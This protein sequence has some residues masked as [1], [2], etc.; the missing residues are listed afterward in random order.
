MSITTLTH[1]IS[2]LKNLY[3]FQQTKMISNK[4]DKEQHLETHDVLLEQIKSLQLKVN[5][6]TH[7]HIEKVNYMSSEINE[8]KQEYEALKYESE[9]DYEMIKDLYDFNKKK[10]NE[11]EILKK[12]N[13]DLENEIVELKKQQQHTYTELIGYIKNLKLDINKLK[14]QN[15][16]KL[17]ISKIDKEKFIELSKLNKQHII[18]NLYNLECFRLSLGDFKE[19]DISQIDKLYSNYLSK[20]EYIINYNSYGQFIPAENTKQLFNGIKLSHFGTPYEMKD[21]IGHRASSNGGRLPADDEIRDFV[22]MF[23][24]TY[25]DKFIFLVK[26]NNMYK[27]YVYE[28]I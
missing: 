22:K 18:M 19:K 20:K 6:V 28:F 7:D 14:E 2:D 16:N 4:Q 5:E 8:L 10:V 21:G 13:E 11:N 3:N 9:L 25:D 12:E 17:E 26:Y 23:K 24:E 1:M 27:I 15:N